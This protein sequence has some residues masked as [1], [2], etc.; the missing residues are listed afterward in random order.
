V[1]G[2]GVFEA[3]VRLGRWQLFPLLVEPL[4]VYW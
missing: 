2:Y 4:K 3:F 1:P